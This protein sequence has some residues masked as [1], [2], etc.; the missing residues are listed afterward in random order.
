MRHGQTAIKRPARGHVSNAF[1]HGWPASRPRP[2]CDTPVQSPRAQSLAP[3][4]LSAPQPLGRCASSGRTAE[5]RV[6]ASPLTHCWA[7]LLLQQEEEEERRRCHIRSRH[8][9]M[10]YRTLDL[11]ER[12]RRAMKIPRAALQRP[13]ASAFVRLYR[14]ADDPAMIRLTGFDHRAFRDL[15]GVYTPIHDCVCVDRDTGVV[16]LKDPK[17]G[18]RR[19]DLDATAL[20][21]LLLAWTRTRGSN[22]L[23]TMVFGQTLSPLNHWLKLGRRVMYRALKQD[24]AGGGQN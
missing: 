6:S 5:Q 15:L 11:D 13:I 21:A 22:H 20:L 23:L 1:A 18:G 14:S 4:Y 8:R 10:H 16:K 19:R 9:R 3:H 7:L 24:H 12:R 17:K 2:A